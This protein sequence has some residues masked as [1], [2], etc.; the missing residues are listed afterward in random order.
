MPEGPIPRVVAGLAV[1][2]WLT[3]AVHG[4]AAQ[5]AAQ[6]LP[7]PLTLE[8][9]LSLADEPHPEMRQARAAV[10]RARARVD[11]AASITGLN[12]EAAAAARWVNPPEAL[13]AQGSE[14][15]RATLSVRKRL[16]DFGRTS[17]LRDAAR[18]E[19]AASEQEL[20]NVRQRR[21]L[22]IMER[23][24]DVILADM[25]FN[26]DNEAM[27]V[28]FVEYDRVRDRHELGQRSDFD[29]M[30][31]EAAYQASRRQRYFSQNRQREVRARLAIALNRPD[32]LSSRLVPPELPALQRALPTVEKLQARALAQN[33]QLLALQNR[34]DAAAERLA[35]ARAGRRPYLDA[36][37][38]VGKF[39]RDL[40]ST[41]TWEAGVSL[42]I[43]LYQG[44]AVSAAVAEARA[45]LEDVQARQEGFRRALGQAVLETWLELDALKIEREQAEVQLTYREYYLDRARTLYEQ[46]VTADLG[47]AMVEY[48]EATRRLR[49]TEYRIALAWARMDALLGTLTEESRP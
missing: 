18:Q 12:A 14:D 38:G 15:H 31:A 49:E 8:H 44:G 19:L 33:P 29:L 21:R 41:N 42:K 27:A 11:Q 2:L 37:A 25:A 46:E 28:A 17:G 30:Q 9:A 6:P 35:A 26:R 7:E 23:F 4:W 40:G 1:P 43:P 16:Y 20:V 3:F 47:D 36:E 39:A 48:T 45:G 24:F 34:V 10:E 13:E 5:G 22:D 32:Q